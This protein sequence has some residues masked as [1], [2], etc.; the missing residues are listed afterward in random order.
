MKRL[1]N[2]SA[3]C[4]LLAVLLYWAVSCKRGLDYVNSKAISPANVWT[5]PG[6]IKAFLTDIYGGLMPK[7]SFDG[8]ASDEGIATVKDLG[9]YQRGVLSAADDKLKF[10]YTYIDKCNY[11]LDQLDAVAPTVIDGSLKKQFIGE[12]KFWRAWTYWG[13]VSNLGGVP[14][15]LHTQNANNPS[16]LKVP[17]S[18]TSD[19]IAQIVRD[20]DSAALLLPANYGNSDFGRITKVA[21]L[22]LKGRVLLWYASPLF[23]PSGDVTRWQAA[24][25]ATKAAVD[26]AKTNGYGLL[27][28][29]RNIWYSTNS[30][31]IMANQYYWPDH[32]AD[33]SCVRAEIFTQGCSN[34]NQ[35]LLPM[36]MAFPKRDG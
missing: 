7:W 34:Q 32:P 27:P 26:T 2:I 12:A 31:M 22:G 3:L 28:N 29:F 16:S 13:M 8:S 11:F 19:C 36:L 4:V 1:K 35:P 23:N 6:M 21:A 24:L 20:L 25:A 9:N 5:D 33:F 10:D 30:E 17:R 14:L 15:I 18:K